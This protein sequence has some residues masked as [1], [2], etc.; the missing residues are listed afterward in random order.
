MKRAISKDSGGACF[1][2]FPVDG[3]LSKPR[4]LVCE[5]FADISVRDVYHTITLQFITIYCNYDL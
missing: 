2:P 1:V 5:S 3:D 4:G